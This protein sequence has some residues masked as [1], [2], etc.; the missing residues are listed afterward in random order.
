[1]SSLARLALEFTKDLFVD[2]EEVRLRAQVA[3]DRYATWVAVAAAMGATV[4][5]QAGRHVE[6]LSRL[7]GRITRSR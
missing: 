5:Y 3:V 4:G 2:V 6:H 1:M 7:V